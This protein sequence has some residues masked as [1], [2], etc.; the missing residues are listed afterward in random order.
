MEVSVDDSLM[1]LTV[2]F[3]NDINVDWNYFL[4]SEASI[5]ADSS[6]KD[7]STLGAQMKIDYDT[8]EY[9]NTVP[10]SAL[11]DFYNYMNDL[12]KLPQSKVDAANAAF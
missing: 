9:E 10:T 2:K 5:M 4:A 8:K 7:R 6:I 11:N 1:E 12:Y 3:P